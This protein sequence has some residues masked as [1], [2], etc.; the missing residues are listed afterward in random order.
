MDI[1]VY[2]GGRVYAIPGGAWGL[3]LVLCLGVTCGSI[4]DIMQCPGM[5]PYRLLAKH[6]LR[7][8]SDLSK[9]DV[10]FFHLPFF[11]GLGRPHLVMLRTYSWLSRITPRGAQRSGCGDPTYVGLTCG[12]HLAHC[13]VFLALHLPFYACHLFGRQL[14]FSAWYVLLPFPQPLYRNNW[15][16]SHKSQKF[17]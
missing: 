17:Y 6:A 16:C 4:W 8:V 14:L 5:E 2:W 11:F 7:P 13:A 9:P 3:F 12:K 15:K 1:H 10:Y